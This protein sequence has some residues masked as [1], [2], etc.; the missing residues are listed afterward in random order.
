MTQANKGSWAAR[1]AH[2]TPQGEVRARRL[3]RLMGLPLPDD[4]PVLQKHMMWLVELGM[5]SEGFSE[6]TPQESY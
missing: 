6:E 2:L 5:G 1:P 4:Q 3:L